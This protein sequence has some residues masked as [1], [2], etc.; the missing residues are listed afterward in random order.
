LDRSG[1]TNVAVD[2]ANG[3][4]AEGQPVVLMYLGGLPN[5]DDIDPRVTVRRFRP[6]DILGGFDVLHS[7]GLRPDLVAGLMALFGRCRAMTT[8]HG[9]FPQHIAFDHG[10]LTSASAWQVW[11]AALSRFDRIVCLSNTMRRFYR[12]SF[13]TDRMEVAYN[14]RAPLAVKPVSADLEAWLHDQRRSER[15]VLSYV[16]SLIGRKNIL[17]LAEAVRK[18]DGLSLIVCGRGPLEPELLSLASRSDSRIR[19]LGHVPDAASVIAQ[20]DWLVLPSYA[21]GLSLALLEAGQLGVPC[22]LSSIAVHREIAAL[23]LGI[24]F[25]HRHFADLESKAR[26]A[27]GSRL[28]PRAQRLEIWNQHFSLTAGVSNYMAIIERVAAS[29]RKTECR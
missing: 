18:A 2:L 8:L 12:D 16:G 15:L 25:D 17:P 27:N 13:P 24:T 23:G 21:E 11:K 29:G 14:F 9:H 7:H 28:P 5:R 22:L 20:S 10:K 4:V 26:Q 19:L 3:L 1:P 6:R